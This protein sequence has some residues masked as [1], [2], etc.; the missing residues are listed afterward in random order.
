MICGNETDLPRMKNPLQTHQST[1]DY[2]LLSKS[3]FGMVLKVAAATASF[4]MSVLV[5]R[6]L[7]A[8]GAGAFFLGLTIVTP[9][10]A[11][12]RLGLDHV[13]TREVAT[14]VQFS[15]LSRINGL[16]KRA[17][18]AIFAVSLCAALTLFS[19]AGILGE[20]V[21]GSDALTICLRWMSVAVMTCPVAWIHASFFQGVSD[22][23][24]FHW[25]QNIGIAFWFVAILAIAVSTFG[26]TIC[27]N[28][29]IAAAIYAIAT[30]VV[31]ITCIW[32]WTSVAGFSWAVALPPGRALAIKATPLLG[33]VMLQ[34]AISFLPAYVVGLVDP[35]ENVAK[36]NAAFRVAQLTSLVLIG[37]NSVV[38]PRFARLHAVG[39]INEL[40]QFVYTITQALVLLC[41]PLVASMLAVPEVFL[42][43]FGSEFSSENEAGL[44]RI[45]AMGQIVNVASGSVG[46]LLNMTGNQVAAFWSTLISLFALLVA[47]YVFAPAYGTEGIAYAQVAGVSFQMVALSVACYRCL[48]FTAAG[49]L[50]SI[51][52]WSNFIGTARR[53]FTHLLGTIREPRRND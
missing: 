11:L 44:L 10:F 48:G 6:L 34:Q 45:L 23:A 18:T 3:A 19:A 17:V 33:L 7:G 50:W 2:G 35:I 5:S 25:Y 14:A 15:D 13:V 52:S 1:P 27:A 39:E 42:S 9:L 20:Q 22:V 32:R 46:G 29:E 24:R 47:L 43:P 37:V 30:C 53:G 26:K 8:A 51:S 31:F 28:V 36:Y 49:G 38:F 21:F 4:G 41:M 16:Y 12:C 40:R